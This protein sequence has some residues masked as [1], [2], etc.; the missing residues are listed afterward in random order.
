V[1]EPV[2]IP[3]TPTRDGRPGTCRV[4]LRIDAA[5]RAFALRAFEFIGMTWNV[6]F[7]LV[8]DEASLLY[9]EAAETTIGTA[10]TIRCDRAYYTRGG[11]F[12]AVE[13]DGDVYWVPRG[14]DV[15]DAD[16]VGTIVRLLGLLDEP[17]PTSDS[18]ACGLSTPSIAQ[19]SEQ[20]RAIAATALAD[21]AARRVL[22][23]AGIRT[24]DLP[25]RWP[26]GKTYAVS[27][28]HDVDS[29][30]IGNPREL[31]RTIAKAVARRRH[32]YWWS[33]GR[34]IT[35]CARRRPGEFWTF[36]RWQRYERERGLC[37]AFYV[38]PKARGVP[39]HRHDPRYDIRGDR[40]SI[41]ADLADA[42]WEVGVHSGIRSRETRERLLR[43]KQTLEQHGVRVDGSRHHYWEID[44]RS[45][46]M[47]FRRHAEAGYRYDASMTWKDVPGFRAG[48]AQPFFPWDPA[49]G[50]RVDL[51]VLPTCLMDGHLFEYLGLS[52]SAAVE[53]GARVVAEA[54]SVGGVAVLDWHERTFADTPM[55][56][57]WR[58]VLDV[59]L[60][61]ILSR[62]DAWVA[63]P[64]DIA[65]HVRMRARATRIEA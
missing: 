17:R 53:A 31:L 15:A 8:D 6:R 34:G 29:P 48:T 4:G 35:A 55:Y 12:C 28:T 16:D 37:S 52:G 60:G 30:E 56:P 36:A 27:L 2:T 63:L 38:Y 39:R 46:A 14:C 11:D 33:L 59:L 45:P 40:W 54:R 47:T 20:R 9:S 64:R 23:R 7:D 1:L 51:V 22:E 43:E 26:G 42:G 62:G 61:D 19:F 25:P 57:G 3:A 58:R 49:T 10:T 5:R 24:A 65:A 32:R 18:R 44:W 21:R 13:R 50:E 41:L